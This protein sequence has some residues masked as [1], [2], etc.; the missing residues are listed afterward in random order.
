MA[1]TDEV[2]TEV[3]MFPLP[4]LGSDMDRATVIAWHV[5]P[6]DSVSKGDVLLDVDTEKAEIEVEVWYDAV[7]TELIAEPGAEIEV[8]APLAMLERESKAI[9]KDRPVPTDRPVRTGQLEPDTTSPVV[10]RASVPQAASDYGGTM[11]NPTPRTVYW[12]SP[13]KR[14]RP[15]PTIDR[16]EERL[17][18]K[19]A[20]TRQ[21]RVRSAI[22]ALMARANREI[23]HYHL[24]R[25]ID[26]TAAASFLE[27]ENEARAVSE[28]I[29]GAAIVLK[30]VGHAA[31]EHPTL[32]GHWVDAAFEPFETVDLGVA[33]HTRGGGLVAPVI[34]DVTARTLDDLMAELRGVVNRVRSGKLRSSDA[35]PGSITVTNLGDAGADSVLGVIHPPQVA[36]VGVGRIRPEPRAI[37]GTVVV[38]DLATFSLSADHRATDGHVGSRFLRSVDEALQS[39]ETLQQPQE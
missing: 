24:M 14:V 30:A 17:R 29:L 10:P 25:E 28:R 3:V 22:G 39:P 33:V 26:L 27:R 1:D 23:P 16:P 34:G 18:N 7:V 15:E 38:R 35:G 37:E 11:V 13:P 21:S 32:N 19:V 2:A 36:L 8:G 6:G 31:A 9:S 4:S 12:P 20:S 5:Q